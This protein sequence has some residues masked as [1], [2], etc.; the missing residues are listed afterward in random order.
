MGWFD[1]PVLSLPNHHSER[2]RF[3]AAHSEPV[4]GSPTTRYDSKSVSKS[5][6]VGNDKLWQRGIFPI[7]KTNGRLSCLFKRVSKRG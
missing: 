4:E 5:G 6:L 3:P 7:A 1:K 2:Y